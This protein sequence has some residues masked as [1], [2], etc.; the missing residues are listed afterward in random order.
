MSSRKKILFVIDSLGIGGAE[1]SLIN[2]L[3][4]ID[5]SRFEV[6]LQL[7]G[8]GGSFT[9]EL[10][11]N[12]ELL[13]E[14]PLFTKL[15]KSN[16]SL[17]KT[18]C[19]LFSKLIYSF[20]IRNRKFDNVKNTILYWK[21]FGKYIPMSSKIF[22]I[23]IAYSQGLPT[24]YVVDKINTRKKYTWVNTIYPLDDKSRKYLRFYY[25]SY[26]GIISVSESVRDYFVN[27]C[28]PEFE[29]K[30]Y[31][32]RDIIDSEF[33]KNKAKENNDLEILSYKNIIVTVGR[34]EK[35]YKG[36][37]LTI[38]AAKI[39]KEKRLK[40]IWVIVGDGP[41]LC[42]MKRLIAENGLS[43]NVLL[44]GS[45]SN[46]YSIINKCD[47]YVQTSRHEGFGL[48]ISEAKILDKPVVITPFNTAALHVENGITGLIS[49]FDP[50]DIADKIQMLI[51]DRKLYESIVNHLKK[52]KKGNIEV[53]EEFYHILSI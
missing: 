51:K 13:P 31:V 22:D 36:F 2:L 14:L 48:T 25:E 35:E 45:T 38:Q 11:K 46:P 28:Y 3:K 50:K 1:R 39:L 9:Y 7:F 52:E 23:A 15:H 41:Y 21:I 18:P 19:L 17:L 37:D 33:I 4:H 12:V 53:I 30:V 40:F 24:M 47:I 5:F 20:I 29:K 49:T 16:L 34:I 8:Y 42:E 6:S 26:N 44:V 27:N 10:P 43:D 32:I